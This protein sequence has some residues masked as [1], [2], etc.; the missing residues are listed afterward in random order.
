MSDN[1]HIC[2]CVCTYRRL[3]LLADLLKKLEEQETG[4]I[5][6]YSIVIVDND[7]RRSA[8]SIVE[9]ACSRKKI[10]INYYVEPKQNI[11]LARNTAIRNAD[12][13]LVAL[14]DDDELPS[15]KWLLNLFTCYTKIKCRGVMG[16]VLPYFKH[17]PP[18]WIVNGKFFVRKSY[19]TGTVIDWRHTRSGNV[20]MEKN[21]FEK[22]GLY[23]DPQLGQTGGG[24]TKLFREAIII[25]RCSFIWCNEA[26]VFECIPLERCRISWFLKRAFRHGGISARVGIYKKTLILR[27]CFLLRTLSTLA[28]LIAV[29]PFSCL[30]GRIVFVKSLIKLFRNAGKLLGTSGFILKEYRG[31]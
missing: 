7:Y 27:T 21:I 8:E 10:K 5:F 23:F 30:A 1:N 6:T 28:F 29:L 3:E 22:Y 18:L 20:L 2:V 17:K 26:E 31:Y 19:P 13:C 4:N 25:H 12:G 9:S 11:S 16:P 15:D 24:D 14:I